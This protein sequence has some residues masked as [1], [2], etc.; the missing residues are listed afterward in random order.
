MQGGPGSLL[1]GGSA[2]NAPQLTAESPLLLLPCAT[3]RP[4]PALGNPCTL[5]SGGSGV[6][7][8]PPAVSP[9]L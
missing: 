8:P 7:S 9:G 2:S 3:L 4:Q 6:P 1:W 5:V